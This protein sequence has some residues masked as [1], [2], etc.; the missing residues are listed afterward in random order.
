MADHVR[1]GIDD[2]L[3]REANLRAVS[4]LML[5]SV[6]EFS[7]IILVCFLGTTIVIMALQR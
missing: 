3:I 7:L 6:L 4:Q 5:R 1:D 2:A